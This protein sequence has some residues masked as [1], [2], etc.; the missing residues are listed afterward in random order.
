MSSSL[1]T[2]EVVSPTEVH[3]HLKQ[4]DTALPLILS[5]RAGMMVS[6]T[7][8]AHYGDGF[9]PPPIRV[10]ARCASWNGA[11]ASAA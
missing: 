11:M 9:D 7:A 8:A 6:P 2:V 5:D 1:D 3:L 10:P 4:P